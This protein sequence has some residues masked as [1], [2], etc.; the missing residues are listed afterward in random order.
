MSRQYSVDPEVLK[1]A[2]KL[3]L[4]GETAEARIKQMAK[5]AA[6]F[7]HPDANHRYRQYIMYIED[8]GRV[9][10]LD[11]MDTD[12]KGYFNKR[13]YDERKA[14]DEPQEATVEYKDGRAR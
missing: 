12:E 5:L 11:V 8:D 2:E 7:T 1:N 10:M 13:T 14:E 3:G 4:Y 6:K 9:S